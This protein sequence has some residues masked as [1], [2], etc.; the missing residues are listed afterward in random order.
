MSSDGRINFYM[1]GSLPMIRKFVVISTMTVGMSLASS[2]FAGSSAEIRHYPGD[3]A[4]VLPMPGDGAP[5]GINSVI[6]HNIAVVNSADTEIEVD[7]VS[8]TLKRKGTVVQTAN[9][10]AKEIAAAA[11]KG[12][13]LQIGGVLE[14]YDAFLQTS[15]F[16][17]NVKLS[18]TPL[19]GPGEGLLLTQK[20]IVYQGN[21]DEVTISA[22]AA[23]GDI[24]ADRTITIAAHDSANEYSFPLK[25]RWFIAAGP[26]LHSHHRWA[27]IQEFALDIVKISADTTTHPGDGSR[28]ENYF[29]FGAPIYAA[30][31]GTVV[32]VVDQYDDDVSLQ[33]NGESDE[34]FQSRANARQ[35]ELIAKGVAAI[36]GNHVII[37]HGNKEYGYYAHM[38][39]GSVAAVAGEI[40][41]KGQQIGALGNSGNST[42][43]H[44]HFHI[45][46]GPD[47]ASSRG[48]P[49]SFDNVSVFENL[50]AGSGILNSGYIVEIT[51]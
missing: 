10:T 7:S 9:I 38:K 25:G 49:V 23:N 22:R 21:A 39:R 36:L 20:L 3:T 11:K 13:D 35:G 44:L 43:P 4:I 51:P 37:D 1:N 34:N 8:L 28:A 47:A 27:P 24:L 16:I 31:D 6:L 5:T 2:A 15:R 42:Q 45:A 32:A 26:S 48:L 33:Q 17:P 50:D 46:E 29:A 18:Q 30:A 19:I 40:V 41:A 12:S 14:A